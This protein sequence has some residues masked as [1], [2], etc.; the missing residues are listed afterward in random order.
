MNRRRRLTYM[1]WGPISTRLA[2][3]WSDGST[4]AWQWAVRLRW[5]LS[6]YLGIGEVFWDR[7]DDCE[8]CGGIPSD[9][10][11]GM[12]RVARR[13][14]RCDARECLDAALPKG[15]ETGR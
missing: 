6:Y 9:M 4:E 14:A 7:W 8:V 15:Q 10:D 11:Y 1:C 5:R 2:G 13:R 12:V 3:K